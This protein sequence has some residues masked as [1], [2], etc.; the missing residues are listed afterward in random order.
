MAT[1]QDSLSVGYKGLSKDRY[2]VLTV[3]TADKH[4]IEIRKQGDKYSLTDKPDIYYDYSV[5]DLNRYISRVTSGFEGVTK[6]KAIDTDKKKVVLYTGPKK[7]ESDH[8]DTES[9]ISEDLLNADAKSLVI[10]GLVKSNVE[11]VDSPVSDVDALS[12]PKE[13]INYDEVEVGSIL[14]DDNLSEFS[15]DET[16]TTTDDIDDKASKKS[17]RQS[18]KV[19]MKQIVDDLQS[20]V[21]DDDLGSLSDVQSNDSNSTSSSKDERDVL[22]EDNDNESDTDNDDDNKDKDNDDDTDEDKDKES[23]GSMLDDIPSIPDAIDKLTVN[24]VVDLDKSEIETVVVYDPT[25]ETKTPIATPTISGEENIEPEVQIVNVDEELRNLI[26]PTLPTANMQLSPASSLSSVISQKENQRVLLAQKYNLPSYRKQL[27]EDLMAKLIDVKNAFKVFDNAKTDNSLQVHC[28]GP[29][30]MSCDANSIIKILDLEETST[31]TPYAVSVKTTKYDPQ[32]P[33][34]IRDIKRPENSEPLINTQLYKDFVLTHATP[35]IVMPIAYFDCGLKKNDEVNVEAKM[36]ITEYANAGHLEEFIKGLARSGAPPETVH[37]SVRLVLFQVLYTLAVIQQ[38]YPGFRHN[39]LHARNILV[40]RHSLENIGSKYF[41][42]I[43]ND[44]ISYKVPARYGFQIYVTDFDWSNLPPMVRNWKPA[45]HPLAM[46]N[47]ITTQKD[48][49]YDM[50]TFVTSFY[51]TL[52]DLGVKLPTELEDFFQTYAV[53]PDDRV[54]YEESGMVIHTFRPLHSELSDHTPLAALNHS[55]FSKYLQSETQ[56]KEA[57]PEF[58]IV[59][60]Y[61]SL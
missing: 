25:A 31:L 56:L 41:E 6:I 17:S 5:D 43:L 22:D 49:Y 44:S 39:D 23:V 11:R 46:K 26:L 36:F 40:H 47:R 50:A 29:I 15:D 14:G 10:D 2:K 34:S 59:S 51:F 38:V 16:G 57:E 55:A 54:S 9:V 58:Q 4:S 45:N 61:V 7:E 53:A 21:E 60:K 37:E 42:Y 24:Q 33:L 19:P 3:K 13:K 48:L 32:I 35:H 8:E 27:V 28:E 52:V 30:C 18:D 12:Q 20:D 1:A